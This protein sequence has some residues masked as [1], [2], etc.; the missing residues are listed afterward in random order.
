M[1]PLLPSHV[2]IGHCDRHL[3]V[4]QLLLLQ[5]RRQALIYRGLRLS[6]L[7]LLLLLLLLLMILLR[8]MLLLLFLL[9]L[10]LLLLLFLLL[11]LVLLL[12]LPP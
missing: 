1:G 4:L 9:L 5:L 6:Q 11:F 2:G 10:L 7:L 3:D 12:L 8:L